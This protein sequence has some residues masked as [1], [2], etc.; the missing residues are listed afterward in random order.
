MTG[1]L[2]TLQERERHIAKQLKLLRATVGG[3][4]VGGVPLESSR[5]R[6]S[7]SA[8]AGSPD[9]YGHDGGS[10]GSEHILLRQYA[11]PQLR[12][13]MKGA[14]A[15]WRSRYIAAAALV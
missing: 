13:E 9:P 8:W 4:C 7:A 6:A 15:A 3:L 2:T 12:G 1:R 11:A 10:V 14:E 5:S